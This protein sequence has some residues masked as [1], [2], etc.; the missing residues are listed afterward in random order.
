ML[1]DMARALDKAVDLDIKSENLVRSSVQNGC[2]VYEAQHGEDITIKIK[3]ETYRSLPGND[4][5][6]LT[7]RSIEGVLSDEFGTDVV[8]NACTTVDDKNTRLTDWNFFNTSLF[9]TGYFIDR[10]NS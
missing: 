1:V 9:Y 6:L 7:H 2:K 3:D 5:P 4:S 8:V 10:L